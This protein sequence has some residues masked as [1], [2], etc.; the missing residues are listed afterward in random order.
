MTKVDQPTILDIL[1]FVFSL[2]I[3]LSF[4][5][6]I[7]AKRIGT[8]VMPFITAAYINALIGS[9]FTKFISN[10]IDVEAAITK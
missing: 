4:D 10:P 2:R 7:T 1:E 9:I 3:F 6:F 8:A 5:I